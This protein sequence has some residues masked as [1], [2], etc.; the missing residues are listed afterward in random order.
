MPTTLPGVLAPL[1]RRPDGQA[2]ELTRRG[3]A[4]DDLVRPGS[5]CRPSTILTL[6]CT[7]KAPARRRAAAR[8]RRCRSAAAGGRRSPAAPA[9]PAARCASRAMPGLSWMM[10]ACSPL[11]PLVISVS[12]A[13]PHH[14]DGVSSPPPS[15]RCGTLRRSTA[16]R[17]STI[18]T[19]T[20]PKTATADEPS[21]SPERSQVDAGDGD[22]LGQHSVLS[23]ARRRSSAGWPAAPARARWRS[24][25]R[26][27]IAT[28]T[29]TS[30]RREDRA[31]ASCRP[32]GS[33]R[34]TNIG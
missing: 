12:A 29:T 13:G 26:A 24:R 19:P 6:L 9:T 25:A 10:R 32:V 8:S 33:P 3:P 4:G 2:G 31:A 17:R 34:E 27:T 14:H 30:L 1:H 18:T 22:D 16:R 20:M 15:S 5:N 21:R 23:G 11:M 7:L 28:P